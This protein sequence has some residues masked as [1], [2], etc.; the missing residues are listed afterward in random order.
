[1]AAAA[2]VSVDLGEVRNARVSGLAKVGGVGVAGEGA[3]RIAEDLRVGVAVRVNQTESL[4]SVL[5]GMLELA[6]RSIIAVM[7]GRVHHAQFRRE[8]AGPPTV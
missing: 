2:K 3:T 7:A 6:L 8:T 5:H 1:M 4:T